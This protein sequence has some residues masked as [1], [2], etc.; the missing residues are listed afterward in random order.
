MRNYGYKIEDVDKIVKGTLTS[1]EIDII[2]KKKLRY[3][4]ECKY[5]HSQGIYTKLKTALYV[6]ARFLD[7][8]K[9]FDKPWLATNTK[10]SS[11][12][13][14]YADGIGMKVTSWEYPEGESL[15]D[16]IQKKKLYPVTII[17]SIDDA[18]KWKLSRSGITL[19]KDLF[20]QDINGIAVRKPLYFAKGWA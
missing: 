10:L 16:M 6:Y 11:K 9:K 4:I 14:T 12:A 15:R 17:K 8:K 18:T 1:H 3:M 13:R 19:A 20:T 7:V 5:H 2:A